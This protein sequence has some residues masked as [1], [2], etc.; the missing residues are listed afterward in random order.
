VNRWRFAFTRRWLTYL[1][2]A[3]VFAIACGLLSNWQLNR[4][5]E[6]AA[7]NTL[8]AKNFD[9]PAVPLGD[10]LPT[11]RSFDA[12]QQWKRVTATGSYVQDDQLLVRNRATDSGPGFE[13]LTPLRLADGSLFIVDRGWVP[14]GNRGG[15][16]DAVPRAQSGQV[17]VT[18]RLKASEPRLHGQSTSGNQVPTIMLRDIHGKLGGAMYTG[19][20][21]VLQTERPAPAHPLTPVVSSPPTKDEGMHWSYMIQWIIF[22]LIGFFGLGYAIRQEYKHRNEDAPEQREREAARAA[23]RARKGKTD[24]ETEDELLDQLH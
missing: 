13:V 2:C 24:A 5:K 15:Q 14:V 10:A 12:E 20:Y 19:A 8:I 4:S 18:V 9:A 6:A 1:A 7:A 17:T 23:K 22:A 11:L 3:I 16:P 21:G